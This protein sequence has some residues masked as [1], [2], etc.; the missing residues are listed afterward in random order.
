MRNLSQ[1]FAETGHARPGL[2]HV[3]HRSPSRERE[4]SQGPDVNR[5]RSASPE[6]VSYVET[7]LEPLATDVALSE[8]FP[9]PLDSLPVSVDDVPEEALGGG[10]AMTDFSACY[11][12][13][14][15]SVVC[16]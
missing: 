4:P 3:S 7:V 6:E 5:Q 16:S 10:T 13:E 15:S 9:A 1:F 2:L 8:L 14:L 11:A 12:R